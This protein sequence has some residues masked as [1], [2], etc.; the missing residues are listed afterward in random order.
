MHIIDR[1]T[2]A[3]QIFGSLNYAVYLRGAGGRSRRVG[4]I[5]RH[6]PGLAFT[7]YPSNSKH[8]GETFTN[9]TACLESLKAD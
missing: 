1:N 5:K 6:G 8:H 2:Y 7:Y 4:V 9:L 3:V